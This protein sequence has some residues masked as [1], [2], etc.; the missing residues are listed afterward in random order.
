MKRWLHKIELWV[1]KIIPY[2]LV[3]LFFVIIGEIF[4]AH[5]I[6][7]YR[8]FVSIIDG[9]IIFIFVIDLIFKYIR[10]RN[11]PK[12]FRSYWL[13]IIAI[14]PAFLVLRVVE[15]FAIIL[16]LEESIGI[17][18]EVIKV[19]DRTIPRASRMHYFSRFIRPLARLPRF[20]KAFSFYE[21][22]TGRHHSYEKK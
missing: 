13:E 10:I 14:F 19:G 5:E 6:E 8:V 4:F 9:F 17:S 20:L 15:E 3:L 18:Q 1:D 22:P 7:P 16:N 11:F 2:L 12:F 21:K